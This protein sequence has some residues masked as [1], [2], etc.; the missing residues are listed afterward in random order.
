MKLLLSILSFT[1]IA[2]ATTTAQT[3]PKVQYFPLQDVR[4]LDSPFKEAQETDKTYILALEPDRLLAPYL[5]EA[6]LTPKS[7]SY[8]NWENTGL[9]GHIG[10]HYLSALSMMYASTGDKAMLD[11][12]NY[13][14]DEL[15]IGRAHV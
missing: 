6:G 13:M 12:L 11:R 15:Q 14:L 5:R 7:E 4:L 1:I 2:V 9:D 8:T 3:Q 10:G